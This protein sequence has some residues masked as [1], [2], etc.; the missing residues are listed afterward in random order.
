M[1]RKYSD[2]PPH[3]EI[4]VTAELIFQNSWDG[5]DV[6]VLMDGDEVLSQNP[7]YSGHTTDVCL[8]GADYG[9]SAYNV[10]GSK[11][12]TDSKTEVEILNSLD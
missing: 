1:K 5:E 4:G 12:H 11:L 9:D 2:L 6:K 7:T 3:F 8:G 10:Q